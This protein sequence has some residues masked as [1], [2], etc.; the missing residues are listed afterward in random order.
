M[1]SKYLNWGYGALVVGIEAATEGSWRLGLALRG[2]AIVM[3]LFGSFYI[4]LVYYSCFYFTF[5]YPYITPIYHS[6]F[7]FI[8]PY[9]YISLNHDKINGALQSPGSLGRLGLKL[10]IHS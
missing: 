2:I 4:T 3:P 9:P 5:H 6:S 8:F 7:H 1:S 10:G